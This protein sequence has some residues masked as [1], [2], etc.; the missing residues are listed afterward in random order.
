MRADAVDA[1]P[2]DGGCTLRLRGASVRALA[3]AL[4]AVVYVGNADWHGVDFLVLS[5]ADAAGAR[6]QTRSAPIELAPVNAA[7]A[8]V[9]ALADGADGAPTLALTEVATTAALGGGAL[10]VA[11]VD[12]ALAHHRRSS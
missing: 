5:A 12:A 9:V 1:A 3:P 8:I 4:E 11:D 6:A 7:P 2:L 10:H